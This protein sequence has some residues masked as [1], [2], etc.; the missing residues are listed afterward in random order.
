MSYKNDYLHTDNV[1]VA[2]LIVEVAM[3]SHAKLI[4]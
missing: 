1:T 3:L 2:M 4:Q